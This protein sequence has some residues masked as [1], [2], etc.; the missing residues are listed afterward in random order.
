MFLRNQVK[1]D[2]V[3]KMS[4]IR[5]QNIGLKDAHLIGYNQIKHSDKANEQSFVHFFLDE[6]KFEVVWNDPEPRLEKLVST[7][8][9]CH[10][11]LV[12]IIPCRYRCKFT[13]HSVRGGAVHTYSLKDLP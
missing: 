8:G 6:Y 2:G 10:L 3:F 12:P 5:L 7:K 4:I 13:T 11:N 9:Y 1:S